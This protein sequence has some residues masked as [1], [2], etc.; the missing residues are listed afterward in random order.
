MCPVPGFYAGG[1]SKTIWWKWFRNVIDRQRFFAWW[2][3][4][5]K[6]MEK[7]VDSGEIATGGSWEHLTWFSLQCSLECSK[8]E[9]GIPHNVMRQ[10]ARIHTHSLR[11]IWKPPKTS[12]CGPSCC[13]D[14]PLLVDYELWIASVASK[15]MNVIV[16][17]SS[18]NTMEKDGVSCVSCMSIAIRGIVWVLLLEGGA[19]C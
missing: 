5:A 7:V 18:N 9:P 17:H 3:E 10:P 19:W 15:K 16:L 2:L 14:D 13:P 1:F 6:V 4:V 8:P 11:N 12:I